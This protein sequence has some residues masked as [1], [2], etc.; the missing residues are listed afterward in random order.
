MVSSKEYPPAIGALLRLAWQDV[1]ERI[2]E[3]VLEDGYTDL[4]RAHVLLFRWP[5][6]DGLRPSELAARNQLSRQTI[7][8]LLSD[9]EKRGYLK[10]TPDPTDGRARIVRLTERGCNLTQVI[11]D[12][13]FATEREWAQVIG[14]RRYGEFRSTLCELVAYT[15]PAEE[16]V[17]RKQSA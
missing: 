12:M 16:A 8:D 6:L 3:G 9:L 13:S 7:N 15:S 10:R 14:E 1:R 17:L 11:S 2:Y 5:T 4:S